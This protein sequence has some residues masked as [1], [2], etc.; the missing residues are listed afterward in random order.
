M[1][2]MKDRGVRV[3]LKSL[4]REAREVL[5]SVDS[6]KLAGDIH[7]TSESES[8]EALREKKG[9]SSRSRLLFGVE[10][11]R[12]ERKKAYEELFDQLGEQQKPHTLFITCSDSRINPT[13]ITSS[14]PG[15]LFIVRNVGNIV[16]PLAD[17]DTPAEGAAL[18]FALGALGVEEII[19]CGHTRCGA[20][21]GVFQGVDSTAFPSVAKWVAPVASEREKYPQIVDP[22]EFVKVHVIEQARNALSYPI[23]RKKIREGQVRIHCWIYDVVFG[24]FLEWTGKGT[25]F[26]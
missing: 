8:A 7:V 16:P 2:E 12:G 4:N 21:K 24:E 5:S 22:E 6:E 18:E 26:V 23:V 15:E 19:I 1:K 10:R 25:E 13:L 11:Y 14:E 3:I 9:Y 20:I 17:D